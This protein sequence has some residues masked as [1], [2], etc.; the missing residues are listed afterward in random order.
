MI[1]VRIGHGLSANIRFD[2][3]LAVVYRCVPSHGAGKIFGPSFSLHVSVEFTLIPLVLAFVLPQLAKLRP[4]PSPAAGRR[5]RAIEP[6]SETG[7]RNW[8]TKIDPTTASG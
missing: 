3:K 2:G 7:A 8:C 5:E 4:P 1:V 6:I